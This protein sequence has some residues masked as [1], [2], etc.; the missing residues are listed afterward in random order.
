MIKRWW[1]TADSTITNAYKPTMTTRGTGSNMGAADSLEVFYIFAQADTGSQESARILV[2]FPTNQISADRAAS[3]I[4]ASGS[5]NFY[6]RMFNAVHPFTVP[7]SGTFLIQAVSQSWSE[8]IG[9]DMD[10]YSD[11]HAV[12]W[13]SASEGTA[14]GLAGGDYHSASSTTTPPGSDFLLTSSFTSGLEDLE[15]DVTPIIETWLENEADSTQ[16]Y[17]NNGFGIQYS[18]SLESGSI[19]YYTKKFY[20]RSS[21]YF[22]KRPII[23]ARWNDSKLDDRGNF[24][25][26]SALATATDNLNTVYLYNYIRGQFVDIPTIGTGNIY[27][28]VYNSSSNG[29]LLTPTPN[30]PVTGGWVSTGIYSASFALDTTASIVYDRWFSGSGPGNENANLGAVCF[31]TG[32]LHVKSFGGDM[33]QAPFGNVQYVTKILNL[34]PEYTRDEVARFRVYSRKKNWNPTIYTKATTEIRPEI[35]EAGYYRIYRVID[36]FDVVSYGTGS[37]NHTKMSFDTSGSYFDFDM[38]TLEG[39]YMYAIRF[40]YQDGANYYEQPEVHKFRVRKDNP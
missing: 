35:P 14:W 3:R 16:T 21:E 38:E 7:S 6:L 37:D 29:E 25:A 33:E 13:M 9:L 31:H 5:V 28:Q 12:N 1:P 36:D 17:S 39:D 26:S 4:P 11:E 22:L 27:V 34:K 30:N 40:V 10:E 23:E 32:T 19:S 20:S 2:K 15:L 24:Y 18:G 8:G